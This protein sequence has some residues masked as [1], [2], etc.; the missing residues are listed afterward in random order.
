[1]RRI[2]FGTVESLQIRG[3]EPTFNTSP[4]IVQSLKFGTQDIVRRSAGNTDFGV[5]KEITELM[6]LFDRCP[7]GLICSIRVQHGLPIQATI[8]WQ[9]PEAS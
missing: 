8:E 3:G 9:N 1:M 7:D 4:R 6:A 5:K 2:Q